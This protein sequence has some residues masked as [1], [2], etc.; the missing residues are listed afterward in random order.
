MLLARELPEQVIGLA[1]QVHRITGPGMLESV[2]DSCCV[3][4]WHKLASP[5]SGKSE[6]QSYTRASN[7]TRASAPTFS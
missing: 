4:S 6:F 2:Y 3:M 1:S 5:L 7:S